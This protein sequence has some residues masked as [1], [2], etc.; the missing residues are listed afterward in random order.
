MVLALRQQT[1]ASSDSPDGNQESFQSRVGHRPYLKVFG[2]PK[3]LH[4]FSRIAFRPWKWVITD[5]KI[6]VVAT[7]TRLG[8][9][10]S[11]AL[12]FEWETLYAYHWGTQQFHE[13]GGALY[14]RWNR[15]PWNSLVRTTYA[16]GIGPSVT[17]APAHYEPGG[18]LKS[19]WLS[20]LNFE[21]NLYHPDH[22]GW[23]LIAR[24]QHRSGVFGTI[25]GVRGGSNFLTLGLRRQF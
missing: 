9:A 19:N 22:P 16:V 3:T 8:E 24:L 11:G 13:L 21:L 17:S 10:F 4:H 6:A 2:G 7:G 14:L 12:T 20:Q 15:F 5:E 23:A 25:N 18:G 1:P